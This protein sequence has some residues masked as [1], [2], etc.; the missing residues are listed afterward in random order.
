MINL[1]VKIRDDI[2]NAVEKL[3]RYRQKGDTQNYKS[4]CD[5][6][7]ILID[8]HYKNFANK[9]Y[10]AGMISFSDEMI[11]KLSVEIS[12]LSTCLDE[13]LEKDDIRDYRNNLISLD[14]LMTIQNRI[15]IECSKLL[16]YVKINSDI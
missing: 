11:P 16:R 6:I 9:G 5:S 3:A 2:N 1:E 7:E 14:K 10:K 4:L 15:Q 12:L 8:M 13:L